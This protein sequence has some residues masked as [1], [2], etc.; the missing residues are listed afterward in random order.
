MNTVHI[1]RNNDDHDD[2]GDNHIDNGQRCCSGDDNVN[3]VTAASLTDN[4]Q[5]QQQDP[6][7]IV[8][9]SPSS[10]A[11]HRHRAAVRAVELPYSYCVSDLPTSSEQRSPEAG[12]NGV[13]DKRKRESTCECLDGIFFA[14]SPF[15]ILRDSTCTF[16]AKM[17]VLLLAWT[18]IFVNT[19]LLAHLRTY[20]HHAAVERCNFTAIT[21]VWSA[22]KSQIVVCVHL[23]V[24]V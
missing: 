4:N 10:S 6:N 14:S 20:A 8:P 24:C 21:Y 16:A 9:P 12:A 11:R 13:S 23:Y 5:Y 19:L 18:V 15:L 2:G 7:I 22:R 3:A 1:Q 17:C